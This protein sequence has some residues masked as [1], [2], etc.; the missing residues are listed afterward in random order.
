LH[1]HWISIMR[2]AYFKIFSASFSITFLSPWIATSNNV[3]VPSLLTDYDAWFIII[4]TTNT[5]TSTIS[6][7]A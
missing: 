3:H 5:T 4:T 7:V 2:P 6:I 1:M